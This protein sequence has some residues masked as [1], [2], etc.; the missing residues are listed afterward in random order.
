MPR[1]PGVRAAR[2]ESRENR[3]GRIRVVDDDLAAVGETKDVDGGA[4]DVGEEVPGR[5]LDLR[6]RSES[7]PDRP[8]G[9]ASATPEVENREPRAPEDD[10]TRAVEYHADDSGTAESEGPNA[11]AR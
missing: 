4:D 7:S 10:E 11:A 8:R 6:G 5:I 2:G 9:R 3:F 1:R